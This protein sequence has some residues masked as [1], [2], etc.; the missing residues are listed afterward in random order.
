[1]ENAKGVAT[2]E[3]NAVLTAK[4]QRTQSGRKGLDWRAKRFAFSRF[5]CVHFASFAPL[6]LKKRRA[7]RGFWAAVI[8]MDPDNTSAIKLYLG[9]SVANIVF[10]LIA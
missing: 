10:A 7:P 5:L 4:A 3:P 6:R 2:D 1:M 9:S 8:Q